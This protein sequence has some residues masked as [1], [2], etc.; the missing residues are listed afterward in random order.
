MSVF[1]DAGGVLSIARLYRVGPV[2]CSYSCAG[3]ISDGG[4]LLPSFSARSG[5]AAPDPECAGRLP[6]E[7]WHRKIGGSF[8]QHNIRD[9][10]VVIDHLVSGIDQRPQRIGT[11]LTDAGRDFRVQV[12]LNCV[13]RAEPPTVEIIIGG[14]HHQ[15]NKSPGGLGLL[16]VGRDGHRVANIKAGRCSVG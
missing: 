16:G 6:R 1:C 3:R 12:L 7:K 13:S 15:F 4:T 8:S 5:K 10:L 2:F 9:V 11:L 14:R